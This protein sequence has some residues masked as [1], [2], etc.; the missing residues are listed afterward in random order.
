VT[1]AI[2]P[3]CRD[4]TAQKE[5]LIW[6]EREAIYICRRDWTTQISLNLFSKLDFTRRRSQKL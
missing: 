3:S 5:P 1:I 4:G 2:R 6:G